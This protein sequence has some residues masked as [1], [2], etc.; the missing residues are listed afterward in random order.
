M[1]G[2]GGGKV[3]AG[4]LETG[5][6]PKGALTVYLHTSQASNFPFPFCMETND[7]QQCSMQGRMRKERIVVRVERKKM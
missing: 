7:R 1:Y 4:G 3:G 6:L 5:K 2:A